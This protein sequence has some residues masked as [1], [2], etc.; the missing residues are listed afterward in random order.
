MAFYSIKDRTHDCNALRASDI[1]SEVILMGWVA[2][3]RNFGGAVFV[4]LRDRT[5]T[6]QIVF[7]SEKS[8]DLLSSAQTLR[9]ED[10]IAVK[11]RVISRGDNATEKIATG[12]IEVEVEELQV[13]SQSDPL[14]FPIRNDVNAS[15]ETRLKYRYLDLRRPE[16]QNNIIARSR[17][18]SFVRNYLVQNG[19]LEIET[20]YMVKYTPGGARNFLVPSR[21][22]RGNFYALAESP[23][24]YK[25]LLMVAGMEKYFQIAKCFRD[26]D[27]RQDRQLEFT[28]IDLEMSF[29]D[30]N[31]IMNLVEGMILHGFSSLGLEFMNNP[32]PKIT[33]EEA[34]NRYGCDKPDTRF[35]MPHVI[36]DSFA[37]NSGIGILESAAQQGSLIKGIC[38]KGEQERFSRKTIDQ[39]TEFVKKE[40]IGGAKGLIWLKHGPDNTFTGSV[41]KLLTEEKSHEL[42][43]LMDSKD[44][45][46][47]FI[48][49]DKP[50]VTH[51]VM[52]NLR[53]HLAAFLNLTDNKKYSALW[54]VRFPM[55]EQNSEGDWVSCHHPFTHPVP[56][57]VSM[58]D[59][60]NKGDVRALAYDLV[61]NG[62]E[63]GGGSVRIHNP[64]TQATVF[65]ALGI[66]DDEA[67]R[68][69]GFLLE[70]FRYGVP[71]HAGFAAGLD[72]LSMLITGADSIRDVIAFP[73][74]VTGADLL[75]GAP[76]AVIEKQLNELGITVKP[77]DS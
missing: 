14:P 73:K 52:D 28:Q 18:V 70:A 48:V 63:V 9:F 51:K 55:F 69:F 6:T 25:Q 31:D 77:S 32:F 56:E 44:G 72:R 64:E 17:F 35:G 66:S 75:T 33:W 54:V 24:I 3:R 13:F 45:D 41:S 38:V 47:I 59:S 60:E 40:E 5:G 57:H 10:V 76:T 16:I 2:A 27:P 29:A 15:L 43:Q 22:N 42:M 26:E 20:P 7:L 4:D 68:L 65:K 67:E 1:D 61:I 34:M 11:G 50:S 12:A 58:L 53:R 62:N 19:F 71:P 49:A 46:T 74:T 8:E 37:A 23:Q 39:L 36:L 30:E 21:I